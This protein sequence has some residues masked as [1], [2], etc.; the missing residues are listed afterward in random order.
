MPP[1]GRGAG[2]WVILLGSGTPLAVVSERLGH[3]SENMTLSVYSHCLPPDRGV[4]ARVWQT[5]LAEV[6]PAACPGGIAHVKHATRESDERS[7]HNAREAAG[8]GTIY[9]GIP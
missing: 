2:P 7:S 9:T 3:A 6:M 1:T 4:A 8:A 5:A